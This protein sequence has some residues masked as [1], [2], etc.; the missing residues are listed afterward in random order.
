MK[1]AS[2]PIPDLA[3]LDGLVGRYEVKG[4]EG[5]EGVGRVEM[6]RRG[7]FLH[8][9]GA[10][11]GLGIVF[12]KRLVVCFG[13]ADKTEIGAYSVVGNKVLGLWVPPGADQADYSACGVEESNQGSDLAW[14]ITRAVAIDGSAYAGKVVRTP[15]HGAVVGVVPVPVH[16][17]W[18]LED[19]EFRSF[20]LDF[21]GAVYS[22]FCLA[23]EA[24]HGLAVYELPGL[25][26]W[27]L[28]SVSGGAVAERL[29][30]K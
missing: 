1:H 3:A 24:E 8:L 12:G 17:T 4:V 15:L 30:R 10:R 25:E 11:V 7:A 6:E 27:G 21:G 16:L 20:G 22:M 9:S 5:V 19:G 18:L 14:R 23:P 13:P 26:G 2:K 29:V 28:T